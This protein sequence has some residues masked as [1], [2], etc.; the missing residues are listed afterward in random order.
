VRAVPEGYL[1]AIQR[2][3]PTLLMDESESL[4]LQELWSKIK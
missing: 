4:R 2:N 1:D 3:D